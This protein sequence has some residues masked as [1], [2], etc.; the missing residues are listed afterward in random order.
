MSGSVKYK[1]L[2]DAEVKLSREKNGVNLLKKAERT[3]WWKE[4]LGKFNDPMIR[5][6]IVA[7]LISIFTGGWIEGVGIAVAVILAVGIA[8]LNE[9]KAGREFDILNQVDDQIPVK[10][11]RNGEFI[12]VPRQDL[13]CGDIIF[14]ETGE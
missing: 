5:I 9:F 10:T 4:L 11:I 7:A 3:P 13:V 12:N 6:L 2:T 14:V 8:F 1:G